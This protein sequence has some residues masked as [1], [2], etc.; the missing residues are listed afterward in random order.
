MGGTSRERVRKGSPRDPFHSNGNETAKTS[1]ERKSARIM[2][3]ARVKCGH[4]SFMNLRV[5]SRVVVMGGKIE[6]I[7]KMREK[8]GK[9]QIRTT[10]LRS[11]KME[12]KSK[13]T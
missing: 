6:G 13:M 12:D 4:L 11:L 1:Q 3:K 10:L 9:E 7:K 2:K 5:I 8:E